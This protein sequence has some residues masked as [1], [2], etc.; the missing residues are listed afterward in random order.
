VQRVQAAIYAALFVV[1][2]GSGALFLSRY[3]TNVQF[4][5][6]FTSGLAGTHSTGGR[7]SPSSSPATTKIPTSSSGRSGPRTQRVA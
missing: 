6:R 3:G 2:G 4:W 5:E 7:R 1:L